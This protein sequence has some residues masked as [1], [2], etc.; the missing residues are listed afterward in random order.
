ML[1]RV[2]EEL[3]EVEQS[4][5]QLPDLTAYMIATPKRGMVDENSPSPKR[6]RGDSNQSAI[7]ADLKL[8]DKATDAAKPSKLISMMQLSQ[9]Q[10]EH[11]KTVAGI[12]IFHKEKECFRKIKP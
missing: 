9:P 3:A 10:K 1:S 5:G 4:I 12:I 2:H 11:D 6:K 7:S 8:S